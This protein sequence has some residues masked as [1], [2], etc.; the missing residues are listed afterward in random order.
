M[1]KI[2]NLK[3]QFRIMRS[4]KILAPLFVCMMLFSGFSIAVTS[5]VREITV[6]EDYRYVGMTPEKITVYTTCKSGSVFTQNFDSLHIEIWKY[7]AN[8]MWEKDMEK[9]YTNEFLVMVST[10]KVH[11]WHKTKFYKLTIL[12]PKD[13]ELYFS[14][15]GN[16]KIRLVL[17]GSISFDV[18][19]NA[20][21]VKPCP[22]DECAE[23]WMNVVNVSALLPERYAEP[24]TPNKD[25]TY[26]RYEDETVYKFLLPTKTDTSSAGWWDG[27]TDLHGSSTGTFRI[28]VVKTKEGSIKP[29]GYLPYIEWKT[30]I[31]YGD[32]YM[33]GFFPQWTQKGLWIVSWR[34][35]G[36]LPFFWTPTDI[37]YYPPAGQEYQ[38][39]YIHWYRL[40]DGKMRFRV[41]TN[42]NLGEP[43]VYCIVIYQNATSIN[44]KSGDYIPKQ[45]WC[46]WQSDLI[47]IDSYSSDSTS[48]FTDK[49]NLESTYT[50]I[51][52]IS[53]NDETPQVTYV[54]EAYEESNLSL[55]AILSVILI[56][57]IVMLVFIYFRK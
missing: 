49:S 10:Y 29:Y 25:L 19:S 57:T 45:E 2:L 6:D 34:F 53:F 7:S 16:T 42:L 28:E 37:I 40:Y 31:Y 4:V 11:W 26:D 41:D 12:I 51:A 55:T 46:K 24:V 44:A 9:T 23:Y 35:T 47:T 13:I 3:E 18:F 20:F 48:S 15:S 52:S 50:K 8:G 38:W 17:N 22:V 43:G 39:T 33:W 56:L 14:Q 30:N 54:Y 36:K 1:K 5:S 32:F 27:K 21:F